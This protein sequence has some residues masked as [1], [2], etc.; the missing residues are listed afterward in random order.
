MSRAFPSPCL[1][2][3]FSEAYR[4]LPEDQKDCS[5][6]A[7]EPG[8]LQELSSWKLMAKSG[9]MTEE[10]LRQCSLLPWMEYE[11]QGMMD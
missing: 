9:E 11:V 4:V 1:R 10:A 8:S 2:M 7:E 3:W 5:Y 6:H